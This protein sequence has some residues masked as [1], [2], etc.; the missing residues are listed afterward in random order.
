MFRELRKEYPYEI[1]IELSDYC[2]AKCPICTRVIEGRDG[3][4]P[5]ATVNRNQISF[6]DFRKWFPPKFIE[7]RLFKM[8]FNGQV[9]ESSLCEDLHD[10]VHY[11]SKCNKNLEY[12]SLTTNGGTRDPDWWYKLGTLMKEMRWGEVVFALDG[13][14]DTHSMYRVNVDWHKVVE[15][16]KAYIAG[17]GRAQWRMLTFKHNEHQVD[18][19]RKLSEE[20]GFN[21]FTLR[22]TAGFNN[23]KF[24]KYSYK[25]KEYVLEPPSDVDFVMKVSEPET[26]CDVVCY[27]VQ[28]V[29]RD[30]GKDGDGFVNRLTIDTRG[31]IHPCC[32]FACEC[33]KVYHKFYETGEPSP[34]C[35]ASDLAM[36]IGTGRRTNM[37]LN[38]VA[39]LIEQQGGIESVSLYYNSFHKI[40]NSP[41][42][43]NT[44]EDSWNKEKHSGDYS[45]CGYMCAKKHRDLEGYRMG[46]KRIDFGVIQ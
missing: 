41:L 14:A 8:R 33:R 42:Y 23:N 7:K 5:S 40:M 6:E 1:Q 32:F 12:L 20:W 2:N 3:L 30:N 19:C 44:L 26:P 9:G 24:F 25:G 34:P 11:I 38:S 18:E 16:A 4:K 43:K 37:Y 45:V 21:A 13:L 35:G 15:N 36:A 28:E 10:I 29:E 31:V 39:N 46:S 27:A 17:G 22:P